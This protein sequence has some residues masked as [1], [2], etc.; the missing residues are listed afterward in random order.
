MNSVD[1]INNSYLG[2]QAGEDSLYTLTFTHQ[3]PGLKYGNIYL[4]DSVSQQTVDITQ[5]GST[6]SFRALPTDTIIKRFKIITTPDISTGVTAPVVNSSQLKIFSSNHTV[7]I[8]NPSD[9]K[10]FLY[11]Y[12]MTG[13]LIQKH[14]FTA[15]SVSTILLNVTPGTYLAKGITKNR[16]VTKNIA[17]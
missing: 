8:D 7:Y 5:S 2:F 3:N 11:L 4:Q 9:E 12:D 17:L 16:T 1:D 10:G 14:P 15:N 13:R 6:Y